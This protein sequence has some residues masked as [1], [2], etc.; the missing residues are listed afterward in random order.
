MCCA[1]QAGDG[2][3]PGE[4][5]SVRGLPGLPSRHEG[6]RPGALRS[7]RQR[8]GEVHEEEDLQVGL[9]SS[10]GR[11]PVVWSGSLK[12]SSPLT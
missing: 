5:L 11:C 12:R 3:R 1:E 9:T 7:H 10:D 2:V 8:G 6:Q 4:H